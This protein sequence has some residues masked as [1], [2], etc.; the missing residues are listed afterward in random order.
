MGYNSQ[1][2][3]LQ[4]V[5]MSPE[6]YARDQHARN[7]AMERLWSHTVGIANRALVTHGNDPHSGLPGREEESPGTG[8][9]GAWGNHYFILTAKHVLEGAQVNDINLFLPSYDSRRLGSGA[10]ERSRCHRSSL[11]LGR[12]CGANGQPRLPRSLFGIC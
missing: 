2:E 7:A 9:A 3:K 8:V 5:C 4:L 10:T 11:R 1:T 6:D 12:P